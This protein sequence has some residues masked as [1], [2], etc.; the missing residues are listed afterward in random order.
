MDK[1][2]LIAY[3]LLVLLEHGNVVEF[4]VETNK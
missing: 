4:L 3:T 1:T 2:L